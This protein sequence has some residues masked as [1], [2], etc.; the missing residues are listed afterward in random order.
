M[1]VADGKDPV[2]A[3]V[4]RRGQDV[5]QRLPATT[6]RP[7]HVV[8][9]HDVAHPLEGVEDLGPAGRVDA[10][11][12][13]Q[14]QEDLTVAHQLLR[15]HVPLHQVDSPQPVD[16]VG[17]RSSFVSQRSRQILVVTTDVRVRR[18]LDVEI[19]LL[20]RPSRHREVVVQRLDRL[21]DRAVGSVCESLGLESR[22]P[23]AEAQIDLHLDGDV[24]AT[25]AVRHVA[26]D[27]EPGRSPRLAPG[28]AGLDRGEVLTDGVGERDRLVRHLPTVDRQGPTTCHDRRFES[29]PKE[30][31]GASLDGRETVVHELNLQGSERG[32]G[33]ERQERWSTRSSASDRHGADDHSRKA[34]IIE[35]TTSG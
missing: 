18:P 27:M 16:R 26:G 22:L 14:G 3:R 25:P 30:S 8:E 10:Q 31:A 23:G 32:T 20:P 29:L 15:L 11:L 4:G 34:D 33:V 35:S 17:A 7:S 24:R 19:D 2:G 13:L 12:G 21:D 5:R 28:R 9:V 6:D 1:S